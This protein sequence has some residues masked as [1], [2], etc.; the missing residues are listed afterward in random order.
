MLFDPEQR[1]LL[2]VIDGTALAFRAF[3]AIRG[4]TDNEGRP[5]GA[6][7]GYV[8]ALLRALEDHPA[9]SVVVAWDRG[10]P[11]F[12]HT[13]EESYKANRED[14][15]EDLRVQFPWMREVTDLMGIP[16]LD[17]SGFEAD[18]IIASLGVQASA[19]GWAVRMFTSDKDL[20]Q[21]VSEHVS[22]CPPPKQSA[23]AV[24]LGP[25][26][27]EEKYGLPPSKMAEWQALVGDS[28]DNI[29]GMPGVGP[30]RATIL[31][32][33][34]EG[35]DD[36]LARGP[37]EEK[38][39]LAENLAEHA[40]SARLALKLVTMVT[41]MDVPAA[42]KLKPSSADFI[43]V[44]DFCKDHSL[45]T[46]AKRFAGFAK[47][48]GLPGFVDKKALA[49]AKA[50]AA[51]RANDAAKAASA[52][53]SPTQ[54]ASLFGAE[55]SLFDA[56]IGGAES[57]VAADENS[58]AARAG[59]AM[60]AGD[61][62]LVR[63]TED[64][65]E[66]HAGLKNSG[67][68]AFDT[69]TTDID[70]MRAKLVGM[71]FSWE[72]GKA[73]YVA[74]NLQPP[75][76]GPDG[77][78]AVEYL[79]AI[80]EDPQI[81]KYGQNLKYDA[82]IMRRHGVPIQG[83]E[84]D[85][86]IAHCL[87]D[88]IS[89]HNLDA[90][91]LNMLG[92]EK[93]PTKALL[94]TGKK[95]L[96]MDLVPVEA[97]AEYACEDAD[98]TFQLVAPLRQGLK[99]AGAEKLFHEVEMPLVG[100]LERM[101]AEGMRVDRERLAEM[102]ITLGK[103]Q[104]ELERKVHELAEEPFNLNSPKQLGP[105]LFDKLKIQEEAGVKRVGRTKTG[106]K[107]DAAT[108]EK[109][110]GIAIVDALLEYRKITKLIGTYVD[111]LPTYIHPET[112]RIHSSFNQ[113]VASTGRLS[114]SNPNL[115]NIPIRTDAG[116]EIRR[117]FIPR[118][119]G[120]VLLSAD[121]SQVELRVVAHLSQD[122]A[123]ISAFRDGADVHA[124][125]AALVFGV[126]ANEV[127][128]E[129]RSRAK[130]INFG[131]LYGMGPQRLARE[132]GFSFK[133]AQDFIDQYFEAL[134]GVRKWLDKTLDDARETG[135]VR[136]LL[137]RHRPADGVN[138]SDGRVRSA[139]ENVAVNTPVQGSAAD[140]IKVAMLRVEDRMVKEELQ[141]RMI[142]QVHDE[143]VFDCPASEVEQLS[144]LVREEMESAFPLD[145]PLKVDLDSGPDWASAH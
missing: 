127:D 94:G 131:I 106:Y 134:P 7:Y 96:T 2:L 73:W 65:V 136:T 85:T 29:K 49:K 48:G 88:P 130:A 66:L 79:R 30:K 103:R 58:P 43:A 52:A 13:M 69:E 99:N 86:M 57:T 1:P 121:Y 41:D 128:P 83:W 91:A 110:E 141:A 31:L 145:V 67:G 104:L 60:A 75:A 118:E 40:D 56:E 113:A 93:I 59:A 87:V 35:L 125:T 115:Q 42:P 126:E 37:A 68:F 16:S 64:L 108:M 81:P 114:S 39:K 144:K 21:V 36:V 4:L 47:D 80:L 19:D 33:K 122:P 17:Q 63:N 138:S 5:S 76:L 123:L 27:I 78:T 26:D 45:N 92:M 101:E 107:T 140:L 109:Y 137:G 70:A 34:Y 98:A 54:G 119:D 111:A 38:G 32:Q 12:R 117:T 89:A 100:V 3:F 8:A 95:A 51:A 120:W 116:R 135:E 97:V 90:M 14:L 62:R 142:L 24:I 129:M 84:F 105:I 82:H 11:T 28:A 71:S 55:P 18:D 10:E 77:E 6:L 112:G 102:R 44:Q 20:A 61:Y 15:D 139:A 9:Q 46:L 124:R 132:T 74:E 50:E 72:N 53:T 25:A 133:E 23:D 143:L 22:Q